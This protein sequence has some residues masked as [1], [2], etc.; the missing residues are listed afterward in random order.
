M[1]SRT[2]NNITSFKLNRLPQFPKTIKLDLNNGI[3]SDNDKN[4]DKEES[5]DII[6]LLLDNNIVDDG[7]DSNIDDTVG[8]NKIIFQL[9]SSITKKKTVEAVQNNRNVLVKLKEGD[10]NK[11]RINSDLINHDDGAPQ[12]E[13]L[14]NKMKIENIYKLINKIKKENEESRV[15][16]INDIEKMINEMKSYKEN[17]VDYWIELTLT[18]VKNQNN[19]LDNSSSDTET[20]VNE[21]ISIN[22]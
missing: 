9:G 12:L 2:N 14:D 11:E 17:L 15:K 16:I 18:Q 4:K 19:N 20:I 21:K 10:S 8:S 13:L 5:D 1:E 6:E 22:K 3:Y 7:T